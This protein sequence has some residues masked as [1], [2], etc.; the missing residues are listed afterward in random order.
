MHRMRSDKCLPGP[1]SCNTFDVHGEPQPEAGPQYSHPI[2]APS[3]VTAV[4]GPRCRGV[5][6]E[7]FLATE[8]I[9]SF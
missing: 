8:K 4:W 3:L 6:I 9:V 5:A 7:R 2:N 1:G